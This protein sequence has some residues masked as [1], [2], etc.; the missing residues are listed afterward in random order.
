MLHVDIMQVLLDHGADP[1]AR[2]NDGSTPTPLLILVAR[3]QNFH[4]PRGQSKVRAC[5]SSMVRL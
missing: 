1:N 5:C 3:F 2:D 4:L